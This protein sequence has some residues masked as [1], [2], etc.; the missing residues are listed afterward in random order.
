MVTLVADKPRDYSQGGIEEYPIIAAQ[1]IFEGCAVGVNPATGFA[2]KLV[3]LDAFAGFAYETA[4]NAAGSAGDKTVRVKSKG[5]VTLSIAGL[6][7]TSNAHP[8]VYASDD[9]TFTL[10][11]T[12]N[13]KIGWVSRWVSTGV[14]VVEFDAFAVL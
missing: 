3:A 6:T 5:K 14:A 4:D 11:S 12:G 8:P 2:R 13:T 1:T 10:T 7:I 9:D